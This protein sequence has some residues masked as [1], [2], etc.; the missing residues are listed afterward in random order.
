M[1]N[2]RIHPALQLRVS[3]E[4]SEVESRLLILKHRL[5]PWRIKAN[6]LAFIQFWAIPDASRR[7]RLLGQRKGVVL[8]LTYEILPA[9]SPALILIFASLFGSQSNSCLA[10]NKDTD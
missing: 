2:E 3:Q 5:E 6:N 4:R 9:L 8:E 7:A 10:L 1:C